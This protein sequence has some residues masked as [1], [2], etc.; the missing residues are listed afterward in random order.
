MTE[1][2]TWNFWFKFRIKSAGSVG[3][4]PLIPVFSSDAGGKRANE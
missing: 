1:T 4:N 2:G 3:T